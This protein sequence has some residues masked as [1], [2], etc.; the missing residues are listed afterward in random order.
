VDQRRALNAGVAEANMAVLGEAFAALGYNTWISTFC[1]FF[2]WKVMRRTAVG[3]QERLE[4][5]EAP[6]G[7]LSEGH[8]LDLTMLATAANFET[9]T[10]GATHMGN[11]DITI[12]DG[13]A[14]LKIIDVSCPRQMLSIMQWIMAGNRGMIYVRVMRTPSAVLY[15]GDFTFEFG[16]GWVLRQSAE[17]AAVIISSGRGV[18]EALAASSECAK[19]GLHVGVVDMPS[20]DEELI[21]EL[22]DSGKPLFIAEQNNGYIWQNFLKVLYRRK[23]VGAS[24]DRVITVN[25]LTAAGKTQF[26]HSGTYEELTAAFGLAASQLASTVK[27][28]LAALKSQ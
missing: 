8:G 28:R 5:I 3:H 7:W 26:I 10:N 13:I 17:D 14:H 19:N 11:D 6:D 23:Q 20:I 4:A 25:T 22:Y 21:L 18:H 2:D 27:E 16:K 12:F 24:L 9:R 1:P 15:G